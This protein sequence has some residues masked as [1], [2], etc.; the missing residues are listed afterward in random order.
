MNIFVPDACLGQTGSFSNSVPGCAYHGLSVIDAQIRFYD[1]S[2]PAT[3]LQTL[4]LAPTAFI[5]GVDL[6]STG[7]T[8]SDLVGVNSGFFDPVQGTIPQ[9]QNYWFHLFLDGP[10]AFL[11]YTLGQ[12]DTPTCIRNHQDATCGTS[13]LEAHVTYTPA[14][15]EPETYAL[16]ASGLVA[17]WLRRRDKAATAA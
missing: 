1:N 10:N 6:V 2:A 7:P 5:N 11:A 14:I 13:T 17:L 3:I 12:A 8:T 15:P 4:N 16:L 9:A